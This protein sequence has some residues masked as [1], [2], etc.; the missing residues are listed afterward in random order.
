VPHTCDEYPLRPEIVRGSS[1]LVVRLEKLPPLECGIPQTRVAYSQQLDVHG[2]RVAANLVN[3]FAAALLGP[4][5]AMHAALD[6]SEK[7][8]GDKRLEIEEMVR[9]HGAR[10]TNN[11]GLSE[12]VLRAQS[13]TSLYSS[14]E[15]KIVKEGLALYKLFKGEKGK[16]VKLPN[17][18]ATAKVTRKKGDNHAYGWAATTVRAR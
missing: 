10:S 11:A 7:I 15:L 14:E 13:A 3:K 16:V 12:G 5:C 6:Q 18:L 17:R 8:D 9:A 2:G 4:L 1:T